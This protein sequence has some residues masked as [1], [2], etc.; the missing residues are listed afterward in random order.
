MKVTHTKF[1]QGTIV[2]QDNAVNLYLPISSMIWLSYF[3]PQIVDLHQI[4]KIN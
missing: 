3:K 2:S 1:G 4:M